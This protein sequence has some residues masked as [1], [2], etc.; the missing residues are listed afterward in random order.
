M[1]VAA[2]VIEDERPATKDAGAL[3]GRRLLFVGGREGR[4]RIRADVLDRHEARPEIRRTLAL[5]HLVHNRLESTLEVRRDRAQVGVRHVPPRGPRH[6]RRNV[7]RPHREV[8]LAGRG[9]RDGDVRRV[10]RTKPEAQRIEELPLRKAAH[11]GVVVGREVAWTRR[12]TSL[13]GWIDPAR[14]R[15]DLEVNGRLRRAQAG[16]PALGGRIVA[17]AVTLAARVGDHQMPAAQD[18]DRSAAAAAGAAGFCVAAARTP[19]SATRDRIPTA[20][21]ATTVTN[22]AATTMQDAIVNDRLND[23]NGRIATS[24]V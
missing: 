19:S 12:E 6:R 20:R 8:A 24:L 21:T 5:G 10:L 9:G 16:E 11:P 4:R 18:E 7:V 1:A 15:A 14:R 2:A 3:R 23:R 13:R 22:T 17:A